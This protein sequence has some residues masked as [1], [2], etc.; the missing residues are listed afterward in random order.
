MDLGEGIYIR[1]I[2]GLLMLAALCA[3]PAY[4]EAETAA[5][6]GGTAAAAADAGMAQAPPSEANEAQEAWTGASGAAEQT[7]A[8]EAEASAEEPKTWDDV[9]VVDGYDTDGPVELL[10]ETKE[11]EE[12]AAPPKKDGVF[13]I[14]GLFELT[15]LNT[16]KLK[17]DKL[18]PGSYHKENTDR[19]KPNLEIDPSYKCDDFSFNG[20]I[21]YN[22]DRGS[23]K[24]LDCKFT[25]PMD[26]GLQ[27]AGGR[28]KTPFG[29]EKLQASYN[30]LTING[31]ELSD[32]LYLGRGWGFNFEAK[33][34]ENSKLLLGII[35]DPRKHAFLSNDYYLNARCA[36][37]LDKHSQL[38]FSAVYGRHGLDGGHSM[39]AGRFGI[40][41]QHAD[42]H[43]RLDAEVIYGSGFNSK[44]GRDSEAL[45]GYVGCAYTLNK[46]LDAILFCDWFDPD[47]RECEKVFY[48]ASR[49]GKAR[50]A[51]GANYYFDRDT[52]RR[53]MVNYE[54][55]LPTEGPCHSEQG[56]YV[57]Y[58]HRF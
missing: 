32:A 45:G 49:N 19:L 43:L 6:P 47:L 1:K 56:L 10:E 5:G 3:A 58:T 28:M 15:Y 54:W 29:I 2:V 7:G 35:N 41:Y 34:S 33:T 26:G 55:K 40:D 18:N 51:V 39:P 21:Q 16:L 24:V 8:A 17:Y 25:V 22:F 48:D 14:N 20:K 23:F 36:F 13:K 11:A 31:S 30:T 27:F 46:N 50:L 9:R 52:V 42:D 37:K 57:K 44:S 4:A 12:N 38:G 53:L